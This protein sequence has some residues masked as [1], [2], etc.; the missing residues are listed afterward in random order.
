MAGAEQQY[1]PAGFAEMFDEG[2]IGGDMGRFQP[3]AIGL[4]GIGGKLPAVIAAATAAELL[5]RD[6][7]LRAAVAP[8]GI[9]GQ[10]A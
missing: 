4:S 10:T 5:Q 2:A 9:L 7:S 1:R 3:R 6:E 8:A